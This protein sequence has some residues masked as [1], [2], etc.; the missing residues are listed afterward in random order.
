[1]PVCL[2]SRMFSPF[3][4]VKLLSAAKWSQQN[5]AHALGNEFSVL[6]HVLHKHSSVSAELAVEQHARSWLSPNPDVLE[7]RRGTV[8]SSVTQCE[9]QMG[10][11]EG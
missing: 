11:L 6:Q 2:F 7:S 1:M 9:V 8:T 5:A 10:F 3:P 4:L